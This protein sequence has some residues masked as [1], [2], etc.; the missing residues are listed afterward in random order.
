M[1]LNLG[2]IVVR[3]CPTRRDDQKGAW[4]NTPF[5]KSHS[6]LKNHH[7]AGVTP[8]GELPLTHPFWT[9]LVLSGH[10][11]NGSGLRYSGTVGQWDTT[12][13]TCRYLLYTHVIRCEC[14][15]HVHNP[16]RSN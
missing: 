12:I 2:Y 16:E 13:V 14:N 5:C 1:I 4:K 9:N 3:R 15:I 6:D 10:G 8:F 7:Q 11:L